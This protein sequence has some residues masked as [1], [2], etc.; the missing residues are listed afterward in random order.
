MD[1]NILLHYFYLYSVSMQLCGIQCITL[2][3]RRHKIHPLDCNTNIA[4]PSCVINSII[5]DGSA[6]L[7][8]GHSYKIGGIQQYYIEPL[9]CS[10]ILR[11]VC[12]D[13]ATH[14][15]CCVNSTEDTC[16]HTHKHTHT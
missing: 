5:L 10:N 15:D 6:L 16:T 3:A 12:F 8:M 14:S 1:W 9:R 4:C 13:S 2:S 11:K 7:G